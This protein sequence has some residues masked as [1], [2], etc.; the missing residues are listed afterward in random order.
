[1]RDARRGARRRARVTAVAAGWSGAGGLAA[2]GVRPA[3]APAVRRAS[4][5]AR[6]LEPQPDLADLDLVAEAERRDGRDLAAVDEG[7]V[8]QPRSSTYQPRPR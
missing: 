2:G 1:M 4:C 6:P 5:G 7:A 8:G 3:V